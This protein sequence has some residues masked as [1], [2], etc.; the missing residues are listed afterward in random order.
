[1]TQMDKDFANDETLRATQYARLFPDS[2]HVDS[3]ETLIQEVEKL[4]FQTTPA[5]NCE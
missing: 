3:L 2:M 4:N 5:T 1:M